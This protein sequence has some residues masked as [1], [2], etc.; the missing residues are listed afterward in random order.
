MADVAIIKSEDDLWSI[1]EQIIEAS[2]QGPFSTVMVDGWRPSLLYFPHE[3]VS[4]SITPTIARSILGFHASISRSYAY[5][6]YGEASLRKLKQSDKE[7][8]EIKAL[9]GGGSNHIEMK[10][11]DI[12]TFLMGLAGKMTAHE[13]VFLITFFFVC[14]FAQDVMSDYMRE[15]HETKRHLADSDGLVKLSEQETKRIGLVT[16]AMKRLPKME[17]VADLAK[18]GKSQLL[19]AAAN[20]LDGATVLGVPVSAEEASVILADEK[21]APVG[22]K[23]DGIYFVDD[24]DTKNEEGH[25]GILRNAKD[26]T[27]VSVSINEGEIPPDDQ[28]NLFT[29]LRRKSRV[30]SVI[31]ARFKGDT[32]ASA[33]IMRATLVD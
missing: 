4:H 10:G 7:L 30:H 23:L 25:R 28:A 9:A 33:T 11:E 13:L 18:E 19:L 17:V 16:E 27:K 29:A 26:G 22:R 12:V 24:I 15:K 3:K 32:V 21:H 14:Y 6:S 20:Q 5:L 2:D 1:F 31:N 8:L